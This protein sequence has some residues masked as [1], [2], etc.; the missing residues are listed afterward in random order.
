MKKRLFKSTLVTSLMTTISR[1]FGLVRDVVIASLFGASAGLDAFIVA[2]R[3][4]NFLRRL[5]AEGGFSQAFV[6]VLAEY[7]ENRDIKEVRALVDQTTATLGLVLFFITLVGVAAAPVFIY[8]FAP[9]FSAEPQKQLLAGDMLRITFPYIFFISLTALAGGILN[10][11]GKFAVPAFTPVLLNLCIISFAIYLS[12]Q[13]EEPVT[14][15]AWAV[16]AA[17]ALQLLFQFPFLLRLGVFPR[18]GFH[19]DREGVQRIMRL[20]LPTL[21]AVSITQINLLIDTLIASYLESGSISWLYFSDRLMEF[22]LGVF[23]VALATVILPSLSR[24]YAGGDSQAYSA[25]MDWAL[26][27]VVLIA[28]PA[29]TGLAMMAAPMLTTLF[30]Y[31]AFSANDVVMASHSLVAYALGLPAFIFIKV[32]ASAFFSRQDTK[33]PVKFGVI[34]MVVNVVLNLV[35]VQFLAHAGLALA[36]SIAAYVNASLLYLYLRKEGHYAPGEGWPVFFFRVIVAVIAMGVFIVLLVPAQG[37]WLDWTALQRGL[38]LALWVLGG[39]MLY[40]ASLVI[41]GIRPRQM[42]APIH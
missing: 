16:L 5:F 3:I 39:A 38:Q 26:R 29:A 30:Q 1:V 9:G 36:T 6:P 24:Q 40:F 35:L 15:L 41:C 8:I 28:L 19:R 27:L 2:F 11:F 32:L 14:A 21:F 7:R 42:T 23:G 22:P 20:M 13:L 12:P 25:T 18:P 4:P 17:G 37:L 34:A 10:T 33:S 31:K